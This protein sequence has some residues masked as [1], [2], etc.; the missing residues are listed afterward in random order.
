MCGR[1]R[2]KGENSI[3]AHGTGRRALFDRGVGDCKTGSFAN[4]CVRG[5]GKKRVVFPVDTVRGMGCS[6]GILAE[7]KQSTI[8]EDER[9]SGS[10]FGSDALRK[11]R[12]FNRKVKRK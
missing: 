11:N 4:R 10:C 3:Q 9:Y 5:G 7:T 2:E 8:P 12:N 6:S 1:K